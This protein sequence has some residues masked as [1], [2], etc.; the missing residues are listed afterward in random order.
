MLEPWIIKRHYWTRKIPALLLY[1]K[2][3]IIKANYLHATANSEK[4]NLLKIGYNKNIE[5]IANGIEIEKI[6][7]NSYLIDGLI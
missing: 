1:Q 3:A 2:N 7:L 6:T 4:E 5:I